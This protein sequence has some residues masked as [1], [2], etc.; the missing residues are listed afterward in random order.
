MTAFSKEAIRLHNETHLT[1]A[2]IAGAVG[3]ARS[4]VRDWLSERTSPSGSRAQR[5]AELSEIVDRLKRII[6]PEYIPVWLVKPIAALD[7][8]TPSQLIARGDARRVAQLVSS[9]EYPGAV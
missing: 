7:D 6:D 8:F 9:L 4:T 1:D 5:V 2:Q 3:A